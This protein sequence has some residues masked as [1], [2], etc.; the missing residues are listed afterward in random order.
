MN[1]NTFTVNGIEIEKAT[2]AAFLKENRKLEAVK[3]LC[4]LANIGLHESKEIIEQFQGGEIENFKYESLKKPSIL[5]EK[6]KPKFGC[7]KKILFLMG[8]MAV[9]FVIFLYFYIGFQH[10]PHHFES[11]K[12]NGLPNISVF[13]ADEEPYIPPGIEVV[14]TA[15]QQPM[16]TMIWVHAQKTNQYIPDNVMESWMEYRKI[17]FSTLV[18]ATDKPTSQEAQAAIVRRYQGEVTSLL[19]QYKAHI[20]IGKCYMGVLQISEKNGPEIA[21][22]T[23]MVSAFNTERGNMGNIQQPLDVVYDFVKY[24]SDP[25]TWYITDFSQ[26]IPFDY[27][28]NN[29]RW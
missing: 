16:D 6:T 8:L 12:N 9:S 19:K 28:L 11:L 17:D 13:F 15:I 26:S 10:I 24:E 21:R 20:E 5:I 2:I 1:K 14:E 29:D 27:I 18:E 22:V 3:Y 7:L 23:G 4:N 25:N